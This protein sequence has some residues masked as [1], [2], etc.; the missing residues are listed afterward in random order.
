MATYQ[1]GTK[2]NILLNLETAINA[3]NGIQFVDW[4]RVYDQS[5]T[6]DRYPFIFIND[7]RTDKTKMLSDITKNEFMV[8]L[9]GGVWAE[10][11]SGVME[12]LGTKLNTFV[13]AV[14]DAVITDRSR[15]SNAYTTDITVIETDA[16]NR[17]PQAIFVMMLN[18]IFFSSE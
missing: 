7:V 12:N 4:Q 2:E 14:K 8:G 16:G 3:I 13:E 15:N 9:V 5:L 11:V 1:K 18:I 17:W 10:E 6:K